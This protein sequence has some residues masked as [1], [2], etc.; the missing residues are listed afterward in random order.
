MSAIQLPYLPE[1]RSILYVP[2]DNPYMVRAK[3]LAKKYKS[4]LRHPA[5]ALVAKNGTVVGEGSIGNNPTH[6]KGCERVFLNLPTGEGYERC[7]GCADHFHSEA[8]AI[9]DAKEKG[10]DARGADLYLWGHWWCCEPCWRAMIEA[11]IA[12]VYL[13]KGSEV[14]FNKSHPANILGRQFE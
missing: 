4:N 10:A 8:R 5:A 11:G 1:N 13:L 2:Q 6:L 3:R 9:A 7:P 12:N 14:F